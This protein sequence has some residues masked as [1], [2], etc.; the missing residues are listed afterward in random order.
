[1]YFLPKIITTTK[2]NRTKN[3]KPPRQTK[4]KNEIKKQTKMLQNKKGLREDPRNKTLISTP[5]LKVP[6]HPLLHF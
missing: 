6:P 3:N 2:Q 5:L 1:M 4:N